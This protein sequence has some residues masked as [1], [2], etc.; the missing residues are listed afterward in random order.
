[1]GN[2]H[3]KSRE[4]EAEH[5]AHL[6]WNPLTKDQAL[7]PGASEYVVYAVEKTLAE[8]AVWNFID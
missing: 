5:G 3:L 1:M 4:A 2:E 8:R 6:D 7:S